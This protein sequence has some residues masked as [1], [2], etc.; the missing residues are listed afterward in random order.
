MKLSNKLV[1]TLVSFL[2]TKFVL[3][4]DAEQAFRRGSYMGIEDF[5]RK[6]YPN[7]L[8]ST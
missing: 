3:C 5:L 6:N 1:A 4:N 8:A 7:F 2:S